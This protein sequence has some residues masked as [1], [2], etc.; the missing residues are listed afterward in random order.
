MVRTGISGHPLVVYSTAVT[1][2]LV[3]LGLGFVGRS[4]QRWAFLAGIALYATDMIALIVT[5][6]LSVFG[7]HAFFVFKW[8][9]GQKA[10]KDLNEAPVSTN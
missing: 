8:F 10:L 1:W 2:L 4:G 7:V 3:M 6:S 5:F 9:Q